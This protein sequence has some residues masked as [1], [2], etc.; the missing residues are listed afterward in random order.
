MADEKLK[1][2]IRKNWKSYHLRDRKTLNVSKY[3]IYGDSPSEI[4]KRL[5]TYNQKEKVLI[6]TKFDRVS[7]IKKYLKKVRIGKRNLK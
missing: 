3:W 4:R 7:E 5:G 2:K 6:P 1:Q